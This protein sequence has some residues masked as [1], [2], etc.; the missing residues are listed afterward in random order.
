[1]QEIKYATGLVNK[2]KYNLGEYYNH[3]ADFF[4]YIERPWDAQEHRVLAKKWQIEKGESN[5]N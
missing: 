1:M 2:K 5:D 4:E 3:M